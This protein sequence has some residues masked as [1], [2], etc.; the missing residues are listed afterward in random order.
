MRIRIQGPATV[1]RRGKPV[2][3]AQTV[4]A[5]DGTE[6]EDECTDY[7]DSALAAR[8]IEGGRVRLWHDSKAKRFFVVTEYTAPQKLPATALR[9]LVAATRGQW[10]DGI[11]E[12]CFEDLAERLGVEIDL[13]PAADAVAADQI[14]DAPAAPKGTRPPNKLA[15]AKAAQGGELKEVRELLDAGADTEVMLQKHTPLHL[16]IL[17]SR[18][19]VAKLLIERGAKVNARTPQGWDPLVLCGQIDSLR[20]GLAAEIARALL[21]HGARPN[22]R[23]GNENWL[24]RSPLDAAEGKPKLRAV[25]REFGATA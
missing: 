20:D 14:A 15:L 21:E 25:L 24:K 19:A 16:A 2:V 22:G 8:G 18:V 9:R 13:T 23:R 3:D 17:Y 11:G 12:G 6:S 4:R 7:I 1:T 5:L 10:S